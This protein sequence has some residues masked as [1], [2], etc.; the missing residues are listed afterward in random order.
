[1]GKTLTCS[2]CWQDTKCR[3]WKRRNWDKMCYQEPSPYL[4]PKREEATREWF[5]QKSE[6]YISSMIRDLVWVSEAVRPEKGLLSEW[7]SRSVC[8]K[9]EGVRV[10]K[11]VTLQRKRAQGVWTC[12]RV[13]LQLSV[14]NPVST[15]IFIT[16]SYPGYWLIS[17]QFLTQWTKVCPSVSVV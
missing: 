3:L 6:R 11:V 15:Q 1:M 9:L 5:R 16:G 13:G 10:G 4:C 2:Q 8:D 12:S 7:I 17:P 14:Q